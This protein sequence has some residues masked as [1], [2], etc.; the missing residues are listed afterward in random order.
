MNERDVI[1][2]L[3]NKHEGDIVKMVEAI[4]S[5]FYFDEDEL[6]KCYDN[7]KC[8]FVTIMDKKYPESLRTSYCP[9][10]LLYYYG[11]YSL[12]LEYRKIYAYVG[13]REASEYG[14]Q[15]A[16][17]LGS[18]CAKKGFIVVSGMASGIDAAV[19]ADSQIKK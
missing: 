7:L 14:I 16:R 19:M 13:S 6:K 8:D 2:Y 1:L 3:S 15:M 11:N 18:D 4:R 9:A 5:K 12:A 17:R 10:M